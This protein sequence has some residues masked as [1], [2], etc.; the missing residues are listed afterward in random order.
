MRSVVHKEMVQGV[1]KADACEDVVQGDG[2][3]RWCK[4]MVQGEWFI[5]LC[6]LVIMHRQRPLML[7]S[8]SYS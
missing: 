3:R 2:A 5:E 7:T 6:R 1:V 8:S 4:E